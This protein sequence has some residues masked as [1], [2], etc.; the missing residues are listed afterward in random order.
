MEKLGYV[1]LSLVAVAWVVLLIS[2]LVMAF[3]W[4]IIGLIGIL[5]IGVLLIKVISDRMKN[6]EDDHYT[7]NVHK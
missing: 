1:L 7:Q 6:K 2:G 3:P 4:G 5:G